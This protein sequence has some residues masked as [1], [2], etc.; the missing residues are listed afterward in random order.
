MIITKKYSD[1][2]LS[3]ISILA[4]TDN[5]VSNISIGYDEEKK[6]WCVCWENDESFAEIS[7]N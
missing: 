2:I 6:K 3:A 4:E 1:A 5:Y 7:D